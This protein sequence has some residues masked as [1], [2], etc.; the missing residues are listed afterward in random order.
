VNWVALF[1]LQGRETRRRFWRIWFSI[2][3]AATV[4]WCASLMAMINL[5]P[6]AAIALLALPPLGA[7]ATALVVRRIH[8]RGKATA[9]APIYVFGPFVLTEPA[10]GLVSSA[11]PWLVAAAVGLSLAGLA[12]S[13]W[14]FVEIGLLKGTAGPNRYGPDPHAG[15]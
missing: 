11:S 15:V 6:W 14:G 3:L 13:V 9:W 7:M 2:N 8:D 4:I 12:L 5:G 10:K 1:S